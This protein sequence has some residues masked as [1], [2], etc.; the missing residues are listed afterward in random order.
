M[1]ETSDNE[2][3]QFLWNVEELEPFESKAQTV[4]EVRSECRAGLCV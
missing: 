1:L 3:A 2:R 4:Y